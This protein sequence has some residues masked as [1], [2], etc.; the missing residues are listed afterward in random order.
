MP[1]YYLIT[2]HVGTFS[3]PTD[4]DRPSQVKCVASKAIGPY[5]RW[6]LIL[7]ERNACVFACNS[8]DSEDKNGLDP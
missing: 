5:A 4:I 6:Q 2:L 8:K 1:E 7:C 3:V